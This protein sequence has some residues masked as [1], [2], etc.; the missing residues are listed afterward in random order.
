M[1]PTV[2]Y[3]AE[4]PLYAAPGLITKPFIVRLTDVGGT[5]YFI[6]GTAYGVLRGTGGDLRTWKTSSGAR[7]ALKR[8]SAIT[9]RWG[10]L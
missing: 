6:A 9:G 4:W 3:W 10:P 1:I 5:C 2:N 8:Y 7:K